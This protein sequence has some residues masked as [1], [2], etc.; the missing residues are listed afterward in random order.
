MYVWSGGVLTATASH[1]WYGWENQKTD[2]AEGTGHNGSISEPVLFT[3]VLV[4][5]AAQ[6]QLRGALAGA[7]RGSAAPRLPPQ[8]VAFGRW[9]ENLLVRT[10]PDTNAIQTGRVRCCCW[11]FLN[12]YLNHKWSC[13]SNIQ[14][15]EPE[16]VILQAQ[17]VVLKYLSSSILCWPSCSWCDWLS[18]LGR[19]FLFSG[20]LDAF[21]FQT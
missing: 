19:I 8:G 16:Y 2:L 5:P 6:P 9:W 21:Q 7:S 4:W 1:F 13:F 11:Y 12:G 3:R 17:Q 10:P 15:R 14:P 18:P 20:S